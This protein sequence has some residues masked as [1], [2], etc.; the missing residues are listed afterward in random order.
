MKFPV[1][2]R[3]EKMTAP[4]TMEE[5]A[6]FI[7]FFMKDADFEQVSQ[8]KLREERIS[9]AFSLKPSPIPNKHA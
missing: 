4:I 5:Y 3:C 7:D 8:Q 9:L 1:I 2:H 6:N